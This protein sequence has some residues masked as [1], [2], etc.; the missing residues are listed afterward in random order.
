[1]LS[2]EGTSGQQQMFD[3]DVEEDDD[4]NHDGDSSG[5]NNDLSDVE[6]I[7]GT[8]ASS[9]DGTSDEDIDKASS[10]PSG[11]DEENSNTTNDDEADDELA[12]FDA[13][14]AQALGT[15]RADGLLPDVSDQSSDSDMDDDQMMALEPHLAQV[16]KERKMAASKKKEKK[17]AKETVV[18]F[19]L[20]VLDL[21]SIYIKKQNQNPTALEIVKPLLEAIRSTQSSQVSRKACQVLAEYSKLCKGKDIPKTDDI[22]SIWTLL[23]DVY[24]Q[25]LKEGSNDYANACS[26]SSILLCKILMRADRTSFTGIGALFVET[27]SQP[28]LHGN[29]RVRPSLL[30]DWSNWY[31]SLLS[32]V[33]N[34]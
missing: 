22:Q 8:D 26:H 6:M 2:K 10:E 14:L 17:D 28:I 13:K 4:V 33:N 23:K 32:T 30:A 15:Q 20:R 24:D 16:F 11:T 29:G 9:V 27:L 1:M 3:Q 7:D 25:A 12:A 5:D 18:N 31:S 21:L 19:K 34:K